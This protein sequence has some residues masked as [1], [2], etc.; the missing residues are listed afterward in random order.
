MQSRTDP[1]NCLPHGKLRVPQA[2]DRH[3]DKQVR[4]IRRAK[5][6][7]NSELR[8]VCDGGAAQSGD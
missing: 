3:R 1:T 5:G 2:K 7:L 4:T 6:G 8:A